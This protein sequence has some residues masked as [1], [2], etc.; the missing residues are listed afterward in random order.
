MTELTEAKGTPFHLKAFAAK[1]S[2][3]PTKQAN[4]DAHY[5][6]IAERV[7]CWPL[8]AD[9]TQIMLSCI[10]QETNTDANTKTVPN[11]AMLFFPD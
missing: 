11:V 1:K 7:A 4:S 10:S 3:P 8:K 2:V 9:G 5:G 6:W